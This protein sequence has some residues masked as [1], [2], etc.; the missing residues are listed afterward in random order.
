MKK[1]MLL[2]LLLT[3]PCIA[4]KPTSA[5][6]AKTSGDCSP[7]VTG[8]N[9][10]FK[11]SCGVGKEQGE[12]IVA[13]LNR[14]LATN[15]TSQVIVKLNEI[16]KRTNPNATVTTYDCQGNMRSDTQSTG[17]F[18][19]NRGSPGEYLEPMLTL[20]NT[21]QFSKLLTECLAQ[22]QLKPEWLT[23]RLFCGW[24]Y[25]AMGDRVNAKK[26]LDEYDASFGP[27]YNDHVCLVLS[28]RLHSSLN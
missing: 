8:S 11:F 1:T 19:M 16:L 20:Y 7:S 13:L 15:D 25:G 3:T 5:G 4:Q 12:Q 14:L 9:N 10:N 24:A 27:A 6:S 28:A 17:Q 26:M 2:L 23:P 18:M 22:I 21:G